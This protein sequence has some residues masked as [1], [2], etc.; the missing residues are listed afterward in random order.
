MHFRPLA[1]AAASLL[2]AAEPVVGFMKLP[3]SE[4]GLP[5]DA[6]GV[7]TITTPTGVK[8]RYKEPGKDGVCETTEGV[9]SYVPSG[10]FPAPIVPLLTQCI[11]TPDTSISARRCMLSSGSS[12]LVMIRPKIR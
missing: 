9:K 6:E 5:A 12:S 7:K 1:V 8:I 10:S 2:L 3:F 4:R 11:A